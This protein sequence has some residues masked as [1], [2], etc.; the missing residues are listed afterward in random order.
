MNKWIGG[1]CFALVVNVILLCNPVE[2][3]ADEVLAVGETGMELLEDCKAKVEEGIEGA[4]REGF[5][6]GYIQ[7]FIDADD[8][9]NY[10]QKVTVRQIRLIFIKFAED[11]PE[12]LHEARGAILHTALAI[13][14]GLKKKP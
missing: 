5:C 12:H 10:P 8:R 11:H 6:Q 4:Y 3:L 1:F 7:G 14:L 2:V 9:I 13:T